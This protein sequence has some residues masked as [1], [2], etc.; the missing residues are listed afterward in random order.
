MNGWLITGVLAGYVGLLFLCA[1]FGERQSA[2]IG[3]QGRRVLFALTL[4]VYC[5]SW[6]FYGAVGS[7]V[8]QGWAF[9]AIYLGPLLFLWFGADLWRRLVV[10]RAHHSISSIADFLAARYGKSPILAAMV[11]LFA[12]IGVLPY[13][14]LQL[15]AISL[16][17][18]VLMPEQTSQQGFDWPSV[19]VFALTAGLATLAM[20]FGTRQLHSNERHG[21]LMLAVALE[22]AVKLLALLLI[23]GFALWQLHQSAEPVPWIASLAWPD[24]LPNGFLA[25]TLVAALAMICLPRQ[26]HVGVVECSDV[27][28]LPPARRLFAG[29]LLL[30]V[31]AILP[32]A[33][34]AGAQLDPRANPDMAV[35]LLPLLYDQQALA[36][37]AF[38]GGF[39]AATGMLLVASVALSIMLSNDLV[40]PLLWRLG[41]LKRDTPHLV[42]WVR[43]IRRLSLL[44]LMLLGYAM[45]RLL[46]SSTQLA[47]IGLLAF[48]A[49]AQFAP[50][51]IGGVYWRGGSKTGVIAGLTAGFMLWALTL[52]LP[53]LIRLGIGTDT[54]L[55]DGLWGIGL[56]RPEALLGSHGL[57]PITHGVLWSLLINTLLYVVVSLRFRPSMRE[58]MQALHFLQLEDHAQPPLYVSTKTAPSRFQLIDL[59]TLAAQI[60]GQALAEQKFKQFA[61]QLEQPFNLYQPADGRWWRMTEQ[62]LAGSIGTATARSLL[63]TAL[64]DKGM[65][66]AEVAGLLDHASQWQRFNQALL[67]TMMDHIAQGI[68]VVDADL[69]LVAWNRRYLELFDYPIDLVYVGCPIADLIRYNAERGECGIGEIQTHIDKRLDWMRRGNPHTFERVRKDGRVIEMR[70]QPIRGGGFVTTFA[71]ITEFRQAAAA[72]EQR[73]H[74]RTEQLED[75]LAQQADARQAAD[76]A[77]QSKSRFVAA[78]SHDLLQPMHAARLFAAS[79]AESQ[80]DPAAQALVQ[81]LDRSLYGAESILSSLLDIARLDTGT[82]Q[83]TLEAVELAPLLADLH[84][85]YAP[86]ATQRGLILRVYP[87]PLWVISDPQWLRRMVQNLLSNALRYTS[88]GRVVMGVRK[89]AQGVRLFVCDTGLGIDTAQQARIFDEFQRGTAASPWGEQGLGLGLAITL[90]MAK[91]LGHRLDLDSAPQRGSRFWLTL[92]AAQAQHRPS[93]PAPTNIPMLAG[94]SILCVDNDEAILMGIHSLLSRWGCQVYCATTLQTALAQQQQHHCQVWLMDQHLD[95]TMTGFQLLQQHLPHGV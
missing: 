82:L 74:E 86:L 14:A 92:P 71:D 76:L 39:S 24:H 4:G 90:R 32:I 95:D 70:G 21:G 27:R 64:H 85:Q 88:Q 8:Q 18:S 29:Y 7:A 23:G 28:D 42:D 10:I 69:H 30:T 44:G 91:R 43:W 19:G 15:Q 66:V 51:L 84:S 9:F 34:W 58:Q 38:L 93:I 49:V 48:A 2:R 37:L 77:N 72:L 68:S 41:W 80:L 73:V 35:L 47:S 5:T 26:F 33:W 50:A 89:S 46:G 52:L 16:S 1:F 25:Q 6:T 87:S 45:Y 17:V 78:A 56:L 12:V 31:L 11:T 79:L 60:S 61:Q 53:S 83:P 13:F 65:G 67:A 63:S 55:T 81:Q 36:L 3:A 22:S 40:L 57:D 94:L 62:L 75:A 20:L 54:W 59:Y